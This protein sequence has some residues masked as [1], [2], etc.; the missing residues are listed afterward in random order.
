MCQHYI[1]FRHRAHTVGVH[2]GNVILGDFAFGAM[3]DGPPISLNQ[4]NAH[5]KN[6]LVIKYTVVEC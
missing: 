4:Q 1:C 6:G 2:N 3:L 5:P